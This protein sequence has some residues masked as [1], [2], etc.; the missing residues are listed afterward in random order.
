MFKK[1]YSR[2]IT[3]AVSGFALLFCPELAQS[4]DLRVTPATIEQ[5]IATAPAGSNILLAQG[6]YGTLRL[7]R[8]FSG[9]GQ[10]VTLRSEDPA[11]PASVSR[12]AIN[13]ANGLVLSDIIFDYRFKPGDDIARE[14]PFQI[15]KS[16]DIT[17][18]NSLFDG[19]HAQS[20]KAVL[21]G[22]GAGFG[23]WIR[24]NNGVLLEANEIRRWHRGLIIFESDNITLRGNNIH[25]MR[26]DGIDFS[27]VQHVLVEG[28]YFHDF[29]RSEKS[30]DHPDMIQF[31]TNGTKRPSIDIRIR[32]NILNS[33]TGMW[34]QSIFIR[35]EEVDTGR[36]GIEMYYRDFDISNNVII[37]AHLH[38]IS[39]GEVDGLSINNNT[40]VRNI[41]AKGTNS[42]KAALWT[43]TIRVNKAAKNVSVKNNIVSK[44]VGA[45]P[46]FG[47][48]VENNLSIQ[49]ERRG[50]AGHYNTVFKDALSNNPSDLTSFTYLAD[51]PA[52]TGKLG[53]DWLLPDAK[54][55]GPFPSWPQL[56]NK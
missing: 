5:T 2:S 1:F 45:E 48:L 12:L 40:L 18:R 54:K 16:T 7:N 8:D 38:G 6:D 25:G 27:A 47:W 51:G 50:A 22:Y 21:N 37:N 41:H 52:G 56:P 19:D 42:N 13:G 17:I 46:A 20:D 4:A 49:P 30:T 15:L 29:I 9:G 36:Q 28:N 44:V 23:L 11:H 33:G 43:P 55:P 34:T 35:N 53:S 31:W 39:I 3:F 14:K 10:A 32:D 24:G 26:S